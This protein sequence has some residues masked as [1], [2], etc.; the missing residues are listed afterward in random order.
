MK[1]ETVEVQGF[2][3]LR[4]QI[5]CAGGLNIL[6]GENGHGKT[7]W[8][9]SICV[10]ATTKSFRTARLQEAIAFG[11]DLAIVR[12]EVRQS[13]EILHDLQIA[14][15]GNTKALSINGKKEPLQRYIRELHAVVFNADELEVVR[16][17]P[18]ARRRFLDNGI[19]SIYPPYLQ[20]QSD[21]SRVIRQKASLLQAAA[22][23][24]HSIDKTRELLQPWNQQL[25]SL[26]ARIHKAR[27]RFVE[28]LN[29]VFERK[30]FGREEISIRY[31]SA[32]E[33]K[34]DLQDYENLIAERLDHRV[35][36]ELV[37]GHALIGT[38]RDDLEISF[39]GR[40][41]RKYGSAGQQR[42]ALLLMQIANFTVFHSQ[43]GEYPLFLLDDIDAELDHRRI[44]Q[45]LDFLQGK[46][47]TF[48]TTSKEGFIQ[49]FGSGAT[50]FRVENGTAKPL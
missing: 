50:N 10:L 45:L 22:D 44:G 14:V 13:A 16:G 3:N 35:Q 43:R 38:H 37:A 30:L 46:T 49:E 6:L 5:A 26:A 32:L 19:V 9:E 48:A 7:N 42:S 4:G 29:E 8:L 1:L 27:I 2:R 40:D 31:M 18:E 28:R 33:G 11:E 39:D 47:Q 41:L 23:Q 15:S 24:Q 17:G 34:G 20:T 25:T 21:Y 36:A 12:G